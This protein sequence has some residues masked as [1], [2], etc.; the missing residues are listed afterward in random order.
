MLNTREMSSRSEIDLAKNPIV[1]RLMAH[2]FVPSRHTV[3]HLSVRPVYQLMEGVT[4]VGLNPKIP[5]KLA[6]RIIDPP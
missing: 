1:S 2:I 6:G 4:H 5:L 3:P